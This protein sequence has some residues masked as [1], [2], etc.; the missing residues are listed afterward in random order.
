MDPRTLYPLGAAA[1][2]GGVALAGFSSR[3]FLR[4]H[5]LV[6]KAR[7]PLIATPADRG[8]PFEDITVR[9]ASGPRAH[10][11]W[12]PGRRNGTLFLM[13]PGSFGN[14]SHEL[15][16]VEFLLS[17]GGSV[18]VADYP[19]YGR[20]EG[21]PGER[22]C[23]QTADA[24]RAMAREELGFAEADTILVGKSMGCALTA[25]LAAQGR[26]RGMLAHSGY[27]SVPDLAAQQYP[28][29]PVRWFCRIHMDTMAWIDACRCPLLYLY[30]EHD[31]IVPMECAWPIFE[32]APEPKRFLTVRGSHVG[33]HWQSTPGLRPLCED[34]VTE[35]SRL[36]H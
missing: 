25:Y 10:G 1:L 29:L 16:T 2:A 15:E 18:L 3:L 4:Q 33:R 34:L 17:F 22:G 32:C 20:S 30:P 36:W 19:G 9:C 24:L 35:R 27:S 5:A 26:Y 28:F 31:E 23:Y 11:W 13:L 8:E 6:F 12:I 21:T 7:R 14:I